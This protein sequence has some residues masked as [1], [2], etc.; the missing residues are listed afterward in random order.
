MTVYFLQPDIRPGQC[1][2]FKGDHGYLVIKL[3]GQ[4]RPTSFTLEH[5]PKSL[6]PSGKIDSAPKQFEVYG[7][8]S[9]QGPGYVLGQYTYEDNGESLQNFQI[10]V[11]IFLEVRCFMLI[12]TALY[13]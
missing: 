11:Y 2:A 4:V 7:L 5:L 8:V 9:E 12:F 1:W 13:Q 6:S 10:Q 3:T